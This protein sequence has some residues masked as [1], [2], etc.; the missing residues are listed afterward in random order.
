MSISHQLVA[1]CQRPV[2]PDAQRQAVSHV[3]DWLGCAA[4]GTTA[5]G[6]EA[7]WQATALPTLA[8]GSA[9]V[10]QDPWRDLLYDASLGNIFEMDDVHR[11]SL[12]HPGPVVVPV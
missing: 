11:T 4:I 2:S 10:G 1:L 7:L 3:I 6:A 12:V 9:D 8:L 5:E